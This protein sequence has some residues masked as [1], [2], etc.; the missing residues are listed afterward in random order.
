MEMMQ[1]N[2][3]LGNI[4]ALAFFRTFHTRVI[5]WDFNFFFANGQPMTDSLLATLM[6]HLNW[7]CK[8]QDKIVAQGS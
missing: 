3:T 2:V 7:Q 6:E 4:F 5:I 1:L 8:M